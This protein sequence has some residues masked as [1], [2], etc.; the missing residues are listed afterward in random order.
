MMSRVAPLPNVETERNARLRAKLERWFTVTPGMLQS[1]DAEGRLIAVSDVWLAKLGYR[2]EEVIGRASSDFLTPE[3][4]ERAVKEALPEF[5]R[6]GRCDNVELQM[7]GKDGRVIDVLLSSVLDDDPAGL[8]RA[9]LA[10]ITDVT[11]LKS[12]ERRLAESEA[13]YRGLVEDQSEMVSLATLEGQL[14]YV[15]HAYARYYGRPPDE[16]VGK[17][18]FDFV[19]K[20]S[21]ASVAERLRT[22]CSVDRTVEGEVQ[23]V[24]PDGQTRWFAWINRALRDAEGNVTA[25]HSVGRNID[26]RVAAEQRLKESEARYR[27]LA[28]HSTDMVLELDLNFKR[29]YVS[30][31]CREMFGYEPEELLGGTSGAMAHPEDA[32]RVSQVLKSLLDGSADRNSVIARRRHRDGRWIWVEAQY[33]AVKDPLTGA[34]TGVIASVRDIS[35]RKAVEDQLADAYRRLEALASVD[36]LTGLANR[37]TFDDAL[38]REYKRAM[39]D[40]KN[41]GLIMVDVDAFKAFNDRYGHPAGDE[42]LRRISK[43]LANTLFRPGDL[44]ARYGGEEFAVLLPDSDEHGAAM[45]GERI[46]QAVLLLAIEHEGSRRHIMTVSVGAASVGR[47]AFGDGPESLL[48]FA[49]RALY[50]AKDGGRNAVV[51]ASSLRPPRALPSSAA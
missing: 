47:N 38:S 45:I 10:V 16:F 6:R 21:Q 19:P 23:M 42:C 46:R 18:L 51:R 2:R 35:T 25:I 49:D 7:V 9:S 22:V 4:R 11:A 24:L 44:A 30:P 40:R 26:E 31:A 32:E 28:D 8:G 36:G 43:T 13:R 12:A 50:S 34:L 37:R 41:L 48:Q 17:S 33:R 20:E 29:R 5:L 1:I 14:R 39:R 27:L 3:S 15:N